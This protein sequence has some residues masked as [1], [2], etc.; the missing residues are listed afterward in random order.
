MTSYSNQRSVCRQSIQRK[1]KPIDASIRKPTTNTAYTRSRPDIYSKQTT[2][3][4]PLQA[5]AHFRNR[6]PV[7][8]HI[9]SK[10][11]AT[12]KSARLASKTPVSQQP[13]SSGQKTAAVTPSRRA[14]R[15]TK[16][17]TEP[18]ETDWVCTPPPRFACR[19]LYLPILNPCK[20][21][22]CS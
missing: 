13:S 17:R 1:R 12:R 9:M 15:Q 21:T 3:T 18:V 10:S 11:Q 5:Y 22:S 19:S 20:S 6:Y 8:S 7:W 2:L 16:N 4:M 14:R